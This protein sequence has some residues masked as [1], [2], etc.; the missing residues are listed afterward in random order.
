MADESTGTRTGSDEWSEIP[1][2]IPNLSESVLQ[3]AGCIL[4]REPD[5]K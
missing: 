2:F 5:R 1:V 4:P 3:E